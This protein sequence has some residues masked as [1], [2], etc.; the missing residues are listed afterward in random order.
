MSVNRI[1]GSFFIALLLLGCVSVSTAFAESR[2]VPLGKEMFEVNPPIAL[3]DITKDLGP[4]DN[5]D[6]GDSWYWI[7]SLKSGND[8]IGFQVHFS[9]NS[10]HDG[11]RVAS[12]NVGIIN[13][14]AKWYRSFEK[15]YP[16]D[17]IKF[18]ASGIDFSGPDFSLKGD[19]KS[20]TLSIK[21]PE[22]SLDV[23]LTP[24][25]P[26]LI[27]KAQ[28]LVYFFG[29]KQYE[30]AFPAMTTEGKVE[31]Q[32]KAYAVTG[33]AW[34]DRQWGGNPFKAGLATKFGSMQWI[35]FAIQLDNKIN[36]SVTQLWE[37]D[38]HQVE[39]VYT[40]VLPDGSHIV[41]EIDP[42]EMS[43]YWESPETGKNYPTHFVL[44]IPGLESKLVIDV[45]YKPQE[46]VSKVGG[47]KYEGMVTIS[48]NVWGKPVK[49]EGYAE[50][51]G[52]W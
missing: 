49:G 19:T 3:V 24:T 31:F 39:L 11:K 46:I 36:I 26:P 30:Y 32:G 16:V 20:Q 48:G 38:T 52:R 15:I 41:G 12:I 7:A 51:V 13:E 4:H 23:K 42:L 9:I 33:P 34:F 45:P 44:S 47:A 18:G 43:D 27:D 17:E 50:M 29:L 25:A 22:W 5:A 28:G 37:F 10:G 40:A 1:W 21:L 6:D 35:W 14:T 8:R 2:Q